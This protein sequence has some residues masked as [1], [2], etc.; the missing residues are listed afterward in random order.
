MI[1]ANQ[2]A[3]CSVRSNA[4]SVSAVGPIQP[5]STTRNDP[6]A[7]SRTPL[8]ALTATATSNIPCT[9]CRFD[10][11]IASFRTINHCNGIGCGSRPGRRTKLTRLIATA[12]RSTEGF[13]ICEPHLLQEQLPSRVTVEVAQQRLKLHLA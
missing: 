6:P 4:A 2:L 8:N 11:A 7:I 12:T 13:L 10:I 3:G 1:C 9:T 5:G